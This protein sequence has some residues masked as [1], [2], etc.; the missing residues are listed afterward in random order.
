M[1]RSLADR[2]FQLRYGGVKAWRGRT[3]AAA[4]GSKHQGDVTVA[5]VAARRVSTEDVQVNDSGVFKILFT[6]SGRNSDYGIRRPKDLV[7]L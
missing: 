5:P 2:T 1:F 7:E 6:R 4:A 3:A